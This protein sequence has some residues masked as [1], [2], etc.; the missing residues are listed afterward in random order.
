MKKHGLKKFGEIGSL[1]IDEDLDILE[2]KGIE[3]KKFYIQ[4]KSLDQE[5]FIKKKNIK[6]KNK[7]LSE[8]YSI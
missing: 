7:N 1:V 8:K 4:I 2:E 6:K 5:K 3:M